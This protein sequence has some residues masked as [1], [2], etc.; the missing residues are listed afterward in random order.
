VIVIV[1]VIVIVEETVLSTA[2]SW[3]TLFMMRSQPLA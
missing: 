3:V 2:M 1:I